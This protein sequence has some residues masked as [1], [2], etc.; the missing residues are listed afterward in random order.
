MTIGRL[1]N[2]YSLSFLLASTRGSAA[3]DAPVH[4]SERLI[5]DLTLAWEAQEQA[6]ASGAVKRMHASG[7]ATLVLAAIRTGGFH[8]ATLAE[9]VQLMPESNAYTYV[10]ADVYAPTS[11]GATVEHQ[12]RRANL[13]GHAWDTYVRRSSWRTVALLE[14]LD[15]RPE[16]T[17]LCLTRDLRQLAD[18]RRRFRCQGVLAESGSNIYILNRLPELAQVLAN[19]FR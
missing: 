3:S 14:E 18:V 1:I 15:S 8:A 13:M 19:L 6:E 12:W 11:I 10:H 5:D 9:A 2:C 7:L 4:T 17:G 16:W